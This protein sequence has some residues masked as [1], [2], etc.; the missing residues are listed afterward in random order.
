[1]SEIWNLIRALI[2]DAPK[3]APVVSALAAMISALA[4]CWTV[5]NA[6][7]ARKEDRR[8]VRPYL[9]FC[10]P[11]AWDQSD[12]KHGIKLRV[13]NQGQRAASNVAGKVILVDCVRLRTLFE[14]SLL[15]A[16]APATP[17]NWFEGWWEEAGLDLPRDLSPHYLYVEAEY[18]DPINGEHYLQEGG[19]RWQGVSDGRSS[20]RFDEMTREEAT[21]V[22]RAVSAKKRLWRTLR[23]ALG[24][25]C[26]RSGGP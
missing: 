7:A 13:K 19:W 22:R 3:W 8:S 9:V 15:V 12:G 17:Q 1:M 26:K 6:R 23:A 18:D 4:A 24:R 5:A 21:R 25:A 16:P 10:E 2:T 11:K 20:G 14:W